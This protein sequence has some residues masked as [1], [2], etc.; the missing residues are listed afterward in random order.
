MLVSSALA[1]Q[2][3]SFISSIIQWRGEEGAI[4][5]A[6]TIMSD[7][8]TASGNSGTFCPA[9]MLSAETSLFHSTQGYTESDSLEE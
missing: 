5:P 3:V 9:Y 1:S 4:V 6:K 8:K 7:V 2:C